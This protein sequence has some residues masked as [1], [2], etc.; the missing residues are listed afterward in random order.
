MA[1][2]ELEVRYRERRYVFPREDVV[3]L[4]ISNTSSENL[5]AWIADRMANLIQE[6]FPQLDLSSLE[7]SVE[8]TAGQRGVVAIEF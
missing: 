1:P 3:I 8:E 6:R 2:G 7:V 5:A 4:P